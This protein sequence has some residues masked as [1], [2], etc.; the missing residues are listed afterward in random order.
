MD[1]LVKDVRI[2]SG[3]VV[4]EVT[5]EVTL[6]ASPRFHARLLEVL[7]TA[8]QRLVIDL[9]KVSHIDS[10][11]VG[12]LVEVYRRV[13]SGGGKMFLAGL[14]PRVRG[15][16]EITKLDRFFPIVAS[17]DEAFAS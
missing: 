12:T 9:S 17:A 5:G 4:V 15:V 2:V 16:F 14:T 11:G 10:A 6:D 13:M 3:G 1:E 8:P 7:D